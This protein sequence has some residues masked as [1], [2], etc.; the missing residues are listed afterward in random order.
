MDTVDKI[1]EKYAGY[2]SEVAK[3][4]TVMWR[5]QLIEGKCGKEHFKTLTAL[6]KKPENQ[7]S[8]QKLMKAGAD[9]SPELTL[10]IAKRCIA[11]DARQPAVMMLL[12]RLSLHDPAAAVRCF[13]SLGATSSREAIR[14][15]EPF[16]T[17]E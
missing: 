12:H 5:E 15:Q 3:L 2:G 10:R 13:Q 11:D 4:I 8:V 9:V 14:C 7:H 6:L 1:G 17:G 16:L